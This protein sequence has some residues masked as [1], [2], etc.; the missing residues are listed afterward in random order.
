MWVYTGET[1][2]G[3]RSLDKLGLGPEVT[4]VSGLLPHRPGKALLFSKGR[5]WR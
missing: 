1:V 4:H 5:V 2:L 3:P